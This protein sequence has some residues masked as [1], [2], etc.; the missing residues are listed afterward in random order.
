MPAGE[1]KATVRRV[2]EGAYNKGNLDALNEL[3]AADFVYRRPPLPDIT[4]LQAY[5]QAIAD[6]RSSFSDVELTFNEII[7]EGETIATRWKFQGTHI[8]QS[9]TIPVPSTGKQVRITGASVT[10]AVTGKAVEEWNHAGWL[11]FFQQLG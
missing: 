11:D 6:V 2:V 5:K 1:L 8:G 9:P 4:G 7:V 10:H 3:Y